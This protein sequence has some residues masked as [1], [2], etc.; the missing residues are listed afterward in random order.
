V[1]HYRDVVRDLP[2]EALFG[3]ELDAEQY[4]KALPVF[5]RYFDL[6]NL[7]AY[8]W[9][10]GRLRRATWREWEEGIQQ[11]LA[12]PAFATAWA[13]V[14]TRA[15]ESFD[16]LRRLLTS[17]ATWRNLPRLQLLLW[18]WPNVARLLRL[19]E[20]VEKFVGPSWAPPL[21]T[22]RGRGQQALPPHLV[23]DVVAAEPAPLEAPK[24]D[25][26]GPPAV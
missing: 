26:A 18:R 3:E 24:V 2:V 4:A 21:S 22:S 16:E 23:A 11:N 6:C 10:R 7:Q 25:P 17:H 20:F 14:S 5:Y 9:E 13:E 12:N 19:P 1:D 15:G 8:L